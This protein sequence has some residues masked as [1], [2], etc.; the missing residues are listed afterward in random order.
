ML[1][2]IVTKQKIYRESALTPSPP[3]KYFPLQ[4]ATF[5]LPANL[6]KAANILQLQACNLIEETDRVK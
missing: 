2:L 4:Q 1:C 5:T 6:C 3:N